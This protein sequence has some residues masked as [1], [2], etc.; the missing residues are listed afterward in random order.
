L[1]I[2]SP[3]SI[4]RT[5]SIQV[6]IHLAFSAG[7]LSA[8]R[9]ENGG[10]EGG[11]AAFTPPISRLSAADE[12]VQQKELNR[13]P[14]KKPRL[15]N[16]GCDDLLTVFAN[17]L[18]QILQFEFT[19]VIIPYRG[20]GVNSTLCLDVLKRTWWWAFLAVLDRSNPP[21]GPSKRL[22]RFINPERMPER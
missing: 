21:Q 8:R 14:Y 10:G 22:E 12:M 17:D 2:L 9:R 7:P 6:T 15:R 16:L 13:Y 11:S 19:A 5:V 4:E 1:N 20:M 3:I 18:V